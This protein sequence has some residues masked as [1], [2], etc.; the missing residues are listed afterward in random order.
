MINTL[1]KYGVEP[2]AVEQP[3]DLS[4]P[5]NKMMLALYLA[6]PEVEN[7]RR[8]LNTFFGMR[9]ARKEGR[10]MGVAPVGYANKVTEIDGK[11]I[12]KYITPEE[13]NASI[14]RWSF[15]E[16]ATGKFNT[17]QIYHI[18]KRKGLSCTRSNFWVA[19]R[20]P[21]YC[22][23]ILVPKYKDEETTLV[24]DKHEPLISEAVFYQVQ[25]ILDRR[26]RNYRP[27]IVTGETLPIRGFLIC[28]T[29]GEILA[30][31]VSKGRSRYY[32]YYHCSDGCP[33][34][35]RAEAVN[36]LFV[37][38]LKKLRPPPAGNRNIN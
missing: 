13:R 4:I 11:R 37:D 16:I 31:S 15:E 22:G 36:G 33:A 38:E 1:R 25:E 12:L 19:L 26:K 28:P 34:R 6:A 2:Q 3:L 30:G 32:S 9:R 8:A 7:D 17:E 24:D 23:K 21:V 35:Y 10:Y 27:K 18:A 5:E 14:M 29:C 20:N